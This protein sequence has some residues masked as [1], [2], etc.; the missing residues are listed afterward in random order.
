MHIQ[1]TPVETKKK[2]DTIQKY[3]KLNSVYA[4]DQ[5]GRK[6]LPRIALLYC[7][8]PVVHM[9]V[10]WQTGEYVD[11]LAVVVLHGLQCER[12][13]V[14]RVCDIR[15]G[16]HEK[17]ARISLAGVVHHVGSSPEEAFPHDTTLHM[18]F[19]VAVLGGQFGISILPR[20]VVTVKQRIRS[21]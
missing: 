16:Q 14:H 6:T 15:H 8:I 9:K 21:C 19:H 17:A 18:Q 3:D 11:Q 12:N 13:G 2:L 4:V 10:H 7:L 1:L 20:I 5:T